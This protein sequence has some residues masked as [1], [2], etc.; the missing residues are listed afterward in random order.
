MGQAKQRKLAGEMPNQQEGFVDNPEWKWVSKP[1]IADQKEII[2]CAVQSILKEARARVADFKD[3]IEDGRN[4]I[5]TAFVVED[6]LRAKLP[7]MEIR[8]AIGYANW[9][10]NAQHPAGAI[11]HNPNSTY[12][13]AA[14]GQIQGF[15][16]HAWVVVDEQYI[17]D[18]TTNTWQTKLDTMAQY[19]GYVVRATWKADY[20]VLNM[21][22]EI[23]TLYKVTNG[24]SHAAYY[25]EKSDLLCGFNDVRVIYAGEALVK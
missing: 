3:R 11:G 12:T 14:F 20:L 18:I 4:C 1:Y 17:V 15:D 2:A 13:E 19:D 7:N 25:E 9:R 22:K 23:A 10:V 16:G 24:Y 6:L 8:S 21:A 5:L